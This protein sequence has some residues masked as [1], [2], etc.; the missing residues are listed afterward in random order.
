METD[1][2]VCH[3][4]RELRHRRDLAIVDEYDTLSGSEKGINGKHVFCFELF[5][6]EVTW[7]VFVMFHVVVFC[8]AFSVPLYRNRSV[9]FHSR[10]LIFVSLKQRDNSSA[11]DWV[12]V[13][14]SVS[15]RTLWSCS[16][17]AITLFVSMAVG[18]H[19]RPEMLSRC[20]RKSIKHN[21]NDCVANIL[22]FVN[23]NSLFS[24]KYRVLHKVETQCLCVLET[25]TSAWSGSQPV[26]RRSVRCILAPRFRS[27]P[28]NRLSCLEILMVRANAWNWLWSL[29][30]FLHH[31]ILIDTEVTFATDTQFLNKLYIARFQIL[32]SESMQMAVF[33]VVSPWSVVE[34]YRRF[35]GSVCL[36]DR[37]DDSNS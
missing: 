30:V 4:A 26:T 23:W 10:N 34:V 2:S 18:V 8:T 13:P 6:W 31:H 16:Y 24:D 22:N 36:H 14:V 9:L 1:G 11:S 25:F 17:G 3:E 5:Q 7:S 37:N 33:W 19:F 12:A 21:M 20:D 29:P 32:M 28:I 27:R 15:Q 35:R